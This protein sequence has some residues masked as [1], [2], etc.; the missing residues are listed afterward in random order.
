MLLAGASRLTRP[1][2]GLPRNQ[3]APSKTFLVAL[4]QTP[5]QR[6]DDDRDQRPFKGLIPRG[7]RRWCWE[8]RTPDPLHAKQVRE[9]NEIEKKH[10]EKPKK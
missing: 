9:E 3:D 5:G 7:F 1:L 4:R 6:R 2:A 10:A 8:T